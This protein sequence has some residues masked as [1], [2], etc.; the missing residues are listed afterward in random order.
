MEFKSEIHVYDL[1]KEVDEAGNERANVYR[2]LC[3]KTINRSKDQDLLP[4][5]EAV[6]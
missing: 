5:R 1:L 4:W 2:N 6:E 3:D